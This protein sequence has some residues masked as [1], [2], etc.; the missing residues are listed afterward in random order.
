MSTVGATK[1]GQLQLNTSAPP[2]SEFNHR[3]NQLVCL[4]ITEKQFVES[5][6]KRFPDIISNWGV[7]LCLRDG[8]IGAGPPELTA[9]CSEWMDSHYDDEGN[10]NL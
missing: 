3:A 4:P 5:V 9:I 1:M 8:V 7:F 2:G 10:V 6:T